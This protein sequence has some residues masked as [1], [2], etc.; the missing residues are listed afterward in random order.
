MYLLF[1]IWIGCLLQQQ[2]IELIVPLI[3]IPALLTNGDEHA[4]IYITKE[5]VLTNPSGALKVMFAGKR[6]PN[7]HIKVLYRVIPT[8]STESINQIGYEFFPTDAE[9][10][11]IPVATEDEAY[12]DYEY[13]VSGL[14]FTSYQI[15]IVFV[16][17]NQ[18]LVPMITDFR[19]IALAV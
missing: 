9:S 14:D 11:T 13:E 17:P 12:F 2:V 6:P 1:L 5:A 16:S 4:A 8:G 10:A 7:T 15:K 18:A 3:P 19:A